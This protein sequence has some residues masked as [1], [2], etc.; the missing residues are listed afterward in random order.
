[1]IIQRTPDELVL[2]FQTGPFFRLLGIAFMLAG[3]A[4]FWQAA[5]NTLQIGFADPMV[6][7]L[8][9]IIISALCL[10]IGTAASFG[11]YSVGF[12]NLERS[13]WIAYGILFPWA[14]LNKPL[15]AISQVYL[16][17][18]VERYEGPPNTASAKELYCLRLGDPAAVRLIAV[19]DESEARKIAMA[20]SQFLN[21]T[22]KEDFAATKPSASVP[23]EQS[24]KTVPPSDTDAPAALR[25]HIF[26]N[27]DD[28]T[29]EI[30]PSGNID[31]STLLPIVVAACIAYGIITHGRLSL[32]T[33]PG[34]DRASNIFGLLV[35][36][37]VVPVAA[38]Q[39][40]LYP[41]LSSGTIAVKDGK[42]FVTARGVLLRTTHIASLNQIAR[43][44]S[45]KSKGALEILTTKR[46]ILIGQAIPEKE[47]DWI[48]AT[49]QQAVCCDALD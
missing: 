32:S 35:L 26:R 45:A 19:E 34:G 24:G 14:K 23:M 36:G 22:L 16:T 21:A 41:L 40:V 8:A 18:E 25:S 15:E 43:I 48:A 4:L 7:R 42:L 10:L 17:H 12:N 5:I 31:V 37:L 46:R 28:L 30:P 13:Y 29:I 9:G 20:V 11:F 38:V 3:G 1:M 44:G 27:G 2:R 49:L 6:N 33:I 39:S 47:L